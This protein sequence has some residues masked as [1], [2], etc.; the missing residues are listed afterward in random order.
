MGEDIKAGD[1]G[2]EWDDVYVK[3]FYTCVGGEVPKG[4]GE[5]VGAFGE[6]VVRLLEDI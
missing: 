3:D 5:D 2:E 1:I 4:A 6:P